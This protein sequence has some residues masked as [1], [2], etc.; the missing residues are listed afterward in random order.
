ME[1]F[2]CLTQPCR[3]PNRPCS[4]TYM[5][6]GFAKITESG[7]ELR[8]ILSA[9]WIQPY[10][11]RQALSFGLGSEN[12][13]STCAPGDQPIPL[14]E[15]KTTPDNN[16]MQRTKHG[17]GGASPLISVLSGRLEDLHGE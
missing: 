14:L 7:R 2:A 6:V 4:A 12:A 11:M 15:C 1:A 8:T 10:R 3:A 5:R 16:E 17:W 9:L 13:F